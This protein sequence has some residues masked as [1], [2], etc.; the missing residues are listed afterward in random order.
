VRSQIH[1]SAIP[2]ANAIVTHVTRKSCARMRR[3]PFAFSCSLGP[4]HANPPDRSD[5][6]PVEGMGD[7]CESCCA[8]RRALSPTSLWQPNW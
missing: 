5:A 4:S 3:R 8:L 2:I 7:S 1:F 6:G